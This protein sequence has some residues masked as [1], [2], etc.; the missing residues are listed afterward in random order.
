MYSLVNS[1]MFVFLT[2]EIKLI[3]WFISISYIIELECYD[4][5]KLIL[6]SI[7]TKRIDQLDFPHKIYAT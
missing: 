1:S 6:M 4:A 7:R 3:G 5:I 2:S